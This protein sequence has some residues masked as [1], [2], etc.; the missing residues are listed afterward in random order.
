MV[1][2]LFNGMSGLDQQRA[3]RG[4][5]WRSSTTGVTAGLIADGIHVHP[6]LVRLAFRVKAPPRSAS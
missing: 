1:T 5:P 6:E 4:H 3:G 2:H